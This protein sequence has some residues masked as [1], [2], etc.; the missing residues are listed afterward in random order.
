MIFCLL[1]SYVLSQD[2]TETDNSK[3]KRVSEIYN[4]KQSTSNYLLLNQVEAIQRRQSNTNI[5][6]RNIVVINQIGDSNIAVSQT[7][8]ANSSLEYIQIGDRNT[9][10][11]SN[12]ILQTT[13]RLIQNG[14]DNAITNFSFG[15]VSNSSLQ[16]LQNGNNLR[17]EKF[18]TNSLTEN[19]S[20]R[21]TG[22]NQTLI[23]R[24]F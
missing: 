18:G 9:I 13:E 8:S 24:S 3:T 22:N 7:N 10:K 17:F 2:K 19:L 11:S 21:I 23:I 5:G 4:F 20:F 1:P 14:N 16:V 12:S 6:D 15:N